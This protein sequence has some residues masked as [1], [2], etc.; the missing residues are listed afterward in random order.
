MNL[1][2][3]YK[4]PWKWTVEDVI[5]NFC[6]P[7]P[8]WSDA[9]CSAPPDAEGLKAAVLTNHISGPTLLDHVDMHVLKDDFGIRALGDRAE[10]L[11]AIERLRNSSSDYVVHRA[12]IQVRDNRVKAHASGLS[13]GFTPALVT[14]QSRIYPSIENHLPRFFPQ[15]VPSTIMSENSVNLRPGETMVDDGH[16]KRRKLNPIQL[17]PVSSE[18]TSAPDK[19]YLGR[20]KVKLDDIFYDTHSKK[21]NESESDDEFSL[22]R[23]HGRPLGQCKFVQGRIRHLLQTDPNKVNGKAVIYPYPER[24]VKE[25]NSRSATVISMVDGKATAM[26][27]NALFIDSTLTAYDNDIEQDTSWNH[28]AKWSKLEG[29]EILPLYNDSGSE[30]DYDASLLDEIELEATENESAPKSRY[31]ARG[32]VD[33][34]VDQA[35][36]NFRSHWQ[37]EKLPQREGRAY[38]LWRQGHGRQG[39]SMLQA[40]RKKLGELQTRLDKLKRHISDEQW[41]SHKAL[42]KQCQVLEPTVDGIAESEWEM[43]VLIGPPP[44]RSATARRTKLKQAQHVYSDQSGDLVESIDSASESADDFID[45]DVGMGDMAIGQDEVMEDNHILKIDDNRSRRCVTTVNHSMN[46]TPRLTSPQIIVIR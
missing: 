34:V 12:N 38:A 1:M 33:E 24:L 42:Q 40:I 8:F 15:P 21:Q 14:P 9:G 30:N 26:K 20:R 2:M 18:V 46:T 28:L 19:S 4:D 32:E 37:E 41:M 13:P 27:K 45:S 16:R 36:Q 5:T 3:D 29:D 35:V 6:C 25:E 31:L 39:H 10:V 44:P 11:H 23:G 43:Q 22:D 17:R 7:G